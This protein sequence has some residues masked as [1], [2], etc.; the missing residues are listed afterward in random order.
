MPDRDNQP[1]QP[2]RRRR[3]EDRPE[4]DPR[5]TR[6]RENDPLRRSF[7]PEPNQP[8]AP[9]EEPRGEP[10]G[11]DEPGAAPELN[12][13]GPGQRFGGATPRDD[14]RNMMNRLQNIDQ[15]AMDAAMAARA[16][17]PQA[18]QGGGGEPIE[19]ENNNLPAVVRRDIARINRE[20]VAGGMV[21]PIW[22]EVGDL[23]GMNDPRVAAMGMMNFS[24]FTRTQHDQILA[25][26]YLNPQ[27]FPAPRGRRGP[28]IPPP[29]ASPNTEREVQSVAFWLEQNAV[30]RSQREDERASHAMWMPPE[31]DYKAMVYEYK[32]SN[33]R[34]HMVIDHIHNPEGAPNQ[35]EEFQN[36]FNLGPDRV[37]LGIYI[38]AYPEQDAVVNLPGRDQKSIS[39]GPSKDAPRLP[40]AGP[41]TSNTPALPGVK[42]RPR[43]PEEN[44]MNKKFASLT[45]Q[46]RFFSNRLDRIDEGLK[47]NFI[48]DSDIDD[49][50]KESLL[51]ESTLSSFLGGTP[52]GQSLV[53]FLHSNYKLS[54]Y[55]DWHELK[56]PGKKTGGNVDR[57]Y[58]NTFKQ[59]PNRFIVIQGRTG[60]VALKPLPAASTPAFSNE[61]TGAEGDNT[62]LYHIVGF[63]EDQR[64]DNQF[65]IVPD[66][67]KS[68]SADEY[69][70]L[71]HRIEA[72]RHATIAPDA[73]ATKFDIPRGGMPFKG[74]P[75]GEN[76]F[77][78]VK[79]VLG[80][81]NAIYVSTTR[82]E[83]ETK[84]GRWVS[85]EELKDDVPP[86]LHASLDRVIAN[87]PKGDL[88]RSVKGWA[89]STSVRNKISIQFGSAREGEEGPEFYIRT[90]GRGTVAQYEPGM[91]RKTGDEPAISDPSRHGAEGSVPYD[92]I[93]ARGEKF[94]QHGEIEKG[95]L[96]GPATPTQYGDDDQAYR[97]YN[98]GG[99]LGRESDPTIM[100]RLMGLKANPVETAVTPM[101]VNML[102][103]TDADLVKRIEA[104]NRAG[105]VDAMMKLAK[106]RQVLTGAL[107][108]L[109]APT[110]NWNSRELRA[111]K[112]LVGKA[113]DQQTRGMSDE[114]KKQYYYAVRGDAMMLRPIMQ[115]VRAGLEELVLPYH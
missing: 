37:V 115:A 8:P 86:E 59:Y 40:G 54:N 91:I 66:K 11:G 21:N 95:D 58:W 93:K 18:G 15:D 103:R 53:R 46:I 33:T 73:A 105:N 22:R 51:S 81:I 36:T 90:S 9:R 32:T 110:P 62:R 25:I 101:L 44:T 111:I 28:G 65:I 10:Q 35:D 57:I 24:R 4:G 64:I 77:D 71:K 96:I 56:V 12:R 76:F 3:P 13:A 38:Y 16:A 83:P 26:A 85:V 112:E 30:S 72:Q 67:P 113:V 92:V 100:G 108:S 78:R 17:R 29:P 114:E 1:D 68:M 43:L 102:K 2:E 63:S 48:S 88:L 52:G 99:A 104:Y 80:G 55:A 47:Y 82:I 97:M 34:F 39:Q 31:A 98:I 7:E 60:V 42:K 19:P 6:D 106:A 20:V 41:K 87:N 89:N 79:Q 23:P 70:A 107:V 49:I 50:I 69:G 74:D 84:K 27:A 45:E 75:R 94:A 5:P 61:P 14:I 109:D